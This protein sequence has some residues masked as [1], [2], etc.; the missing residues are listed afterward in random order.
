[1]E[2]PSFKSIFPSQMDIRTLSAD[3]SSNLRETPYGF[4]LQ[5]REFQKKCTCLLCSRGTPPCLYVKSPSWSTIVE[6]VLY[7]LHQTHTDNRFFFL[8]KNVY[9][10][11]DSHWNVLGLPKKNTINWK[12]QVVDALCHDPKAFLSGKEEYSKRG[13]WGL[14][15]IHEDPWNPSKI[16]PTQLPSFVTINGNEDDPIIVSG[17]NEPVHEPNQAVLP[18]IKYILNEQEDQQITL[19]NWL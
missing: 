2:L 17:I 11:I 6:V 16:W 8:K 1:M 10:F 3:S 19:F 5:R 15:N 13:F 14:K 7:V 4:S 18:S 9:P 12:K